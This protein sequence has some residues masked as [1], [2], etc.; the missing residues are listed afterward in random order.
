MTKTL[1]NAKIILS[2][3]LKAIYLDKLQQLIK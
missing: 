2:V 1:F 3:E